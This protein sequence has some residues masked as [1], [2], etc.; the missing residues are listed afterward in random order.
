[1]AATEQGD[2]QLVDHVILP[3]DDLADLLFEFPVSLVQQVD[4]V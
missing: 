3:D 1:M 4:G 2:Q